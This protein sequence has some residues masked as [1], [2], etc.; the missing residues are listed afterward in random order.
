M[1]IKEPLLIAASLFTIGMASADNQGGHFGHQ[2]SS[3]DDKKFTFSF[4]AGIGIPFGDFAKTSALGGTNAMPWTDS[5]HANGFANKGFHFDVGVSW[6]FTD[7][8]GVAARIG[9]TICSFNAS[10]YQSAYPT[11]PNIPANQET[12]M[13]NGSHYVGE[14]FIGPMFHIPAGDQ[15]SFDIKLMAGIVSEQYPDWTISSTDTLS[16]AAEEYKYAHASDFGYCVSAM[17]RYK[18]DANIGLSLTASYVGATI[19]LPGWVYSNTTP[20]GFTYSEFSFQD[21]T[22]SLSMLTITG[23][24]TISF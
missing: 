6:R 9:G 15:F 3:N 12:V 1:Q 10:A 14:Y 18:L 11:V 23:G 21:R 5:T 13:A 17:A 4:N 8:I 24:L 16:H 22:M 19:T 7:Y 20:S 2:M